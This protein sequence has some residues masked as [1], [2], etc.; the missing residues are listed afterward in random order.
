MGDE[1]TVAG[2][3]QVEE[4]LPEA[5]R[6]ARR[7]V[8]DEAY[9]KALQQRMIDGVEPAMVVVHLWRLAWGDH[10]IHHKTAEN[11]ERFSRMREA[12]KRLREEH[13]DKARALDALVMGASTILAEDVDA[14]P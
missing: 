1:L 8:G 9:Q 2:P 11:D 7:L 4:R 13:P 6:I 14:E 5:V 12:A 10:R 3:S